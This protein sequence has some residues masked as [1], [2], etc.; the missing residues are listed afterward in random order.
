VIERTLACLNRFRH[1]TIHPELRLGIH[2][3]FLH[4]SCALIC[5]N[6]L[7]PSCT[8]AVLNNRPNHDNGDEGLRIETCLVRYLS[9]RSW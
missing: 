5:F 2:Q 7:I 8:L 4:L 9:C 3:A 6:I 1:L